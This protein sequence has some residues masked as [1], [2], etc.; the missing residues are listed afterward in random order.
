MHAK[1][2]ILER[3]KILEEARTRKQNKMREEH[4]NQQLAN[5]K[6]KPDVKP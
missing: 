3:F 2:E 6:A 5:L 4:T 1:T